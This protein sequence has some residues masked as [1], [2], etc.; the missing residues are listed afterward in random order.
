[1]RSS[2]IGEGLI[3]WVNAPFSLIG[4]VLALL[5]AQAA[6]AVVVVPVGTRARWARQIRLG[7]TGVRAFVPYD[8]NNPHLC[9]RGSRH[10]ASR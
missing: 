8:P 5:R 4:R 6:V 3:A 9:M 7:A 10:G 2:K 1:M